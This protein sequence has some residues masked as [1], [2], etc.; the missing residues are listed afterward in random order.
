MRNTTMKANFLD[1]HKR[2]WNDAE[3]LFAAACYANADQLYGMAAE[4]GLKQLMVQFG[5]AVDSATGSPTE[6]VDKTGGKPYF[7]AVTAAPFA[8]SKA[9]V[10]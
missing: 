6:A 8:P 3:R 10:P 4:C 1:A 5:M 9:V 2:H 7:R